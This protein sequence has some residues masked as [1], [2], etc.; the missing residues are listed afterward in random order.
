[1]AIVQLEASLL[2]DA[3]V[4]W[5]PLVEEAHLRAA[6][7]SGSLVEH[8]E[9]VQ[10]TQDC[11]ANHESKNRDQ[12]PVLGEPENDLDVCPVP[13]VAKVMGE[14]GPRVVVV[15][16]GEENADTVFVDWRGVVVVA[17]DKRQEE[18][19]GGC[20]DG[21]VGERPATVVVGQRVNGLEEE[22]VAGDGAHGIVGD[23][24]GDC[25]ADPGWVGEKRVEAAVASLR[26]LV[27]VW[28]IEGVVRTS[29][30][31]M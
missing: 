6:G 13:A 11:E 9:L 21:D 30:R 7:A 24:G 19:T 8:K 17:P 27:L 1:M 5:H 12:Q 14:E 18:G 31:S 16:L 28:L 23:S 4:E 2:A 29:S 26:L 22:G 10:H 15:F 3:A 20:H 25:A